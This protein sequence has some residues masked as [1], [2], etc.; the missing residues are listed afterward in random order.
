MFYKG[1]YRF[2]RKS[3]VSNP[4]FRRKS[5]FF[6]PCFYRKSVVLISVGITYLP[7]YYIMCIEL[8]EI[9]AWCF[10]GFKSGK[11]PGRNL[12]QL[13]THYIINRQISNAHRNQNYTFPIKTRAKKHTFPT[14]IGVG[15]HT[16]PKKAVFTLIK[17]GF[18]PINHPFL[19]R[20]FS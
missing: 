18:Y 4:N 7:I 12:L 2:F 3:V 20:R 8:K 16:F 11:A 19:Q 15:N 17:H 5:V 13:Y 9:S 6:S 1:K 10:A 14:K